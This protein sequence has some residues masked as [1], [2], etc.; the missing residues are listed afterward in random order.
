MLLFWGVLMAIRGTGLTS[1]PAPG[2]V[3]QDQGGRGDHRGGL[4]R[5]SLGAGESGVR[6]EKVGFDAW[7]AVGFAL[8]WAWAYPEEL[9]RVE[10]VCVNSQH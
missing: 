4:R 3:G 10:C 9:C 1:A 8:C 6:E 5:H 2:T 7:W